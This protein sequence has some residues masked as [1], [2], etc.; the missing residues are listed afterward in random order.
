MSLYGISSNDDCRAR[1]DE[2]LELKERASKA[3]TKEEVGAVKSRLAEYYRMGD[4]QEGKAQMTRVEQAFFWPAIVEAYVRS[5][6]LN[7]PRTWQEGL[8]EI[9]SNLRYYRPQDT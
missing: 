7:S 4:S 9:E 5:P 6:N 3:M 1:I 8:S 2:L